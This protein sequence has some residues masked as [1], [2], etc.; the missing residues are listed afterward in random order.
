MTGGIEPEDIIMNTIDK[1]DYKIS[2]KK[3]FPKK[4]QEEQLK[5]IRIIK[6][7]P[8]VKKKI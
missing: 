7:I 8:R 3:F 5:E 4:I 6:K 1:E 2:R